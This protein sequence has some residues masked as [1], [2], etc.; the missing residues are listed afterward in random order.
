PASLD[1][2]GGVNYATS[3]IMRI[4]HFADLHI[5]V[6]NYGRVDPTTGLSTRLLDFLAALDELV[7][8]AIAQRVDLVLFAGDAYKSRDPSQTQQRELARRLARLSAEGIPTFLLVG[9]HDL[10]HALGRA[11]AVEIYDTLSVPRVYVGDR[12]RTY[13]VETRCGP[14]QVVAM[15]WPRRSVLFSHDELRSMT[16]EEATHEL[17]RRLADGVAAQAQSLDTNTPAILA[18][19]V[20]VQGATVGSERSMMLGRDHILSPSA[21]A[22]PQLD[23]VA[24]GHIHKHQV[25]Y[26]R[27][28]MAYSGSLQRVDFSEEEDPKGFCLVELDPNRP[29]G[30]RLV[31]F[32]F[33]QVTA[34]PFLTI[35]VELQPG[36][37][38]PT[39][40][41]VKAVLRRRV[42]DA[43]VRLRIRLPEELAPLLRESEVRAAL[44]AA[45]YV[46]GV[47]REVTSPRRTRLEA[48]AARSLGP[49]EALAQYLDARSTAPNRKAL[50]LRRAQELIEESRDVEERAG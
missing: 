41:V 8:Y 36:D 4:L 12:L 26:Q 37:Q 1:T 9:N 45:H 35:D 19:H 30:Q 32:Q 33:Q 49:E 50:L 21:L 24:L 16:I 38:D 34:R 46:A 42:A 7:E 22:Y 5:G 28:V 11:S 10:P 17:E 27:P 31:D 6:E 47:Y 3:P 39:D 48:G 29:Q 14:L 2:P 43:V 40:T 23:Y 15:P 20:T 44:R 18:G 25:L 13:S